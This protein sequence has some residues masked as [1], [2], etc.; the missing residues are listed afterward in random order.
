MKI[1][2]Y[3][4]SLGNLFGKGSVLE[5][6]RLAR[7]TFTDAAECLKSVEKS[8]SKFKSAEM[9]AIQ[10][11]YS[12]VNRNTAGKTLFAHIAANIN[13]I[14][15]NID[16]LEAIVAGEFDEKIAAQGLDY[17]RANVLQLTDAIVFCSRFT[18]KLITHA[19]KLESAALREEKKMSAIESTEVLG[20]EETYIKEGLV[21]YCQAMAVLTASSAQNSDRISKIPEI[22]ANDANYGTLRGTVGDATLDPFGF[23]ATNFRYNPFRAFGMAR[24]EAKAARAREAEVELQMAQLRLMQMERARQGKEDPALEREIRY[25]QSLIDDLAREIADLTGE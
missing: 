1:V 2:Q 8:L 7:T 24:V 16:T 25:T 5:D 6:L 15:A 14:K 9:K 19:L 18:I 3:I 17:R 13:N 22:L 23:T 11:A 21:A 12:T 10:N 20:F 4:R